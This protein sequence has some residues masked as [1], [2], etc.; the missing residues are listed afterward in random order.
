[1]ITLVTMLLALSLSSWAI[2]EDL[3]NVQWI[4]CYDGDTCAFNVL[5][6]AVFGTDIGVRLSGIDAPEISGKCA[7]EKLLAVEAREFL[8]SQLKGANVVLQ[9]VFRDKYFR[10]EATVLANDVNVNQL[11][12]QK[13][14][15]V[16][17]SGQGPRKDWCA[18]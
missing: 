2:A 1:M 8:R 11:L 14:Y 12:V 7:K 16:L 13:G 6:P 17:Y 4:A 5:L 3:S 10:I 9:N 18:P 15:A